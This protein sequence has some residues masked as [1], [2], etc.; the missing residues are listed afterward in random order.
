[1]KL[2]LEYPK[3]DDYFGTCFRNMLAVDVTSA[4]SIGKILDQLSVM[5]AVNSFLGGLVERKLIKLVAH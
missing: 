4:I 3:L 2:S 1:M 5:V